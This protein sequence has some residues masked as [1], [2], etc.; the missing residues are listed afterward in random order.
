MPYHRKDKD[1]ANAPEIIASLK[2]H[3]YEVTKTERPVDIHI[4]DPDS[5]KGGWVEIKVPGKKVTA[6][7]H[8][9][10]FLSE[11]QQPGTIV[12]SEGEAL[13]FA[14]NF[15]GWSD[16]QKDEIAKL[17]IRNPE[18]KLFTMLLIEKTL[19]NCGSNG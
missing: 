2:G 5:G 7:R 16:K 10:K 15:E 12:T 8:Q 18:S 1:D 3:G 14:S 6:K 4:Y 9:L 11:C 19:E 17:L 13:V